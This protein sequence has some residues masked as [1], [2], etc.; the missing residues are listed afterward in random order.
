MVW[1]SFEMNHGEHQAIGG[2]D[3]KKKLGRPAQRKHKNLAPWR[4]L[5]NVN[6]S[7]MKKNQAIAQVT[8]WPLLAAT[9][10]PAT[11][12]DAL[13]QS[14]SEIS[15]AQLTDLRSISF[16][17]I[18]KN[19]GGLWPSSALTKLRSCQALSMPCHKLIMM[20]ISWLDK[21]FDHIL[22]PQSFLF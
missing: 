20:I 22:N 2:G 10:P 19:L 21:M 1:I 5:Q 12:L 3:S 7:C 8:G 15:F 14:S 16:I 6:N 11:G 9:L 4:N 17:K 13:D 18:T